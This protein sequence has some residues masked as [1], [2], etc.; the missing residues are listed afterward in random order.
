M[1]VAILVATLYLQKPVSDKPLEVDHI[2]SNRSDNR[3]ENLRWVDHKGNM[4]NAFDNGGCKKIKK[5]VLMIDPKTNQVIKEFESA[6]EAGRQ[7]NIDNSNISRA[8]RGDYK[9][10]GGYM[11]KY[12][13]ENQNNSKP[14][15][16]NRIKGNM[17]TD[18]IN[19]I[20]Q[21][22]EEFPKDHLISK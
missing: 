2:N 11:W 6:M 13:N 8:C 4:K 5:P 14:I 9:T 22:F 20:L 10:S 17:N 1:F 7:M 16:I 19:R 15:R 18:M 3:V 12:K 21:L